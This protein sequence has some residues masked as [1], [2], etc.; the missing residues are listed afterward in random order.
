MIL[1]EEAAIPPGRKSFVSKFCEL[2]DYGTSEILSY[3]LHTGMFLT[4]NG[5]KYRL[6]DEQIEHLAGPSADP[7]ERI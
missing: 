5:G 7:S 2:T 6:S 3:S 4:R 1:V